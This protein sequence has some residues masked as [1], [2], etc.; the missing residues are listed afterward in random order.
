MDAVDNLLPPSAIFSLNIFFS[1]IS[2]VVMIIVVLPMTMVVF[3]PFLY[4][5]YKILTYF[6]CTQRSLKRL[7]SVNKSP[8]F[9]HFTETLS[10]VEVIRSYGAMENFIDENRKRLDASTTSYLMINVCN[11]WL[12]VRLEAIGNTIVFVA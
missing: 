6:N 10:G 4:V 7:D 8:I 5:Y 2:S 12:A 1:S 3:A 11:R 9:S